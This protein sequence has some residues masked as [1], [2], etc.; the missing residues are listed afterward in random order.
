M[1]RRNS[2]ITGE[3]TPASPHPSIPIDQP[4]PDYATALAALLTNTTEVPHVRQ[5]GSP[6]M[7]RDT[8]TDPS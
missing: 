8:G 1:K 3:V 5:Q 2:M 7:A 4:Q 6:A